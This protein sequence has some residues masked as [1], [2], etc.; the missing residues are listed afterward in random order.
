MEKI[1]I[2]NQKSFFFFHFCSLDFMK[3][4]QQ[5]QIFWSK[6]TDDFVQIFWILSIFQKFNWWGFFIGDF[7]RWIGLIKLISTNFHTESSYYIWNRFFLLNLYQRYFIFLDRNWEKIFFQ[8]GIFFVDWNKNNDKLFFVK[9]FWV[10]QLKGSK[11]KFTDSNLSPLV[12]PNCCDWS[13]LPI[14]KKHFFYRIFSN[15]FLVRNVRKFF[16]GEISW[17][18]F[19]IGKGHEVLILRPRR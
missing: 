14:S 7:C 17:E 4:F 13:D 1:G 8:S 11:Q 9:I 12:I 5:L 2:K 6:A 10:E 3:I 18:D 19:V 15:S 16:V